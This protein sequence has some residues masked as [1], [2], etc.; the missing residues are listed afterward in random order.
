MFY[1]L[2]VLKNGYKVLINK[3]PCVVIE[4]ECI[5]PGKGQAFSRVR[6]KNIKTGRILEKTLKSGESVESAYIREIKLIYLYR[7]G[8]LFIFMN[9]QNFDQVDIHYQIIGNAVKWLQEQC[10]YLVTFWNNNPI[11]ITPPDYMQLKIIKTISVVKNVSVSSGTKLATVSTGA[12]I[13][14]PC[15]IQIGDLIKINTHLST[16]ISRVKDDD[17]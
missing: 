4:N 12:V 15:F 10:S 3:E 16:Y 2:N 8:E 7:D 9:K 13:K 5:K 6:F 1:H 11:L 17:I 14:V